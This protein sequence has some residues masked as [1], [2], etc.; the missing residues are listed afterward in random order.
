MDSKSQIISI[1]VLCIKIGLA[2]LKGVR[3]QSKKSQIK[4]IIIIVVLVVWYF[5]NRENKKNCI[6]FILAKLRSTRLIVIFVGVYFFHSVL[7][8]YCFYTVRFFYEQSKFAK[9]VYIYIY[10]Y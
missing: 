10:K 3:F 6:F 9:S 4:I 5:K 7:G 1:Y 2:E 8:S